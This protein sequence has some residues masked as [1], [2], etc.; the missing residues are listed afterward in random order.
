MSKKF[1]LQLV[2][3]VSKAAPT[4]NK[5][6]RSLGHYGTNLWKLV[7]SQYD[8]VDAGGCELLT[9]ACQALDRAEA[10]RDIINR[11]GEMVTARNGSLK[12]HPAMKP[13]LAARAFVVKTLARMGLHLE[14][15]RAGRGRPGGIGYTGEYDE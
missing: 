3:N 9:Q 13:E 11:D 2:S 14:P 10:L 15:V 1:P 7:T 5:P 8:I 12:E 6:A 4:A